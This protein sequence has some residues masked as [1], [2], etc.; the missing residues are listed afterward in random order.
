M[1]S[2]QELKIGL[3]AQGRFLSRGALDELAAPKKDKK[4]LIPHR[5]R[6]TRL[7]GTESDSLHLCSVEIT[8]MKD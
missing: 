4:I 8:L 2:N 5:A 7:I 1:Q 6:A 3:N